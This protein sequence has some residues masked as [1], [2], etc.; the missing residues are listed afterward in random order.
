M[1]RYCSG[2]DGVILP[3]DRFS[4]SAMTLY[5]R[6]RISESSALTQA[7]VLWYSQSLTSGGAYEEL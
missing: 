4:R 7:D 5:L 3:C 1:I 2:I 6:Y